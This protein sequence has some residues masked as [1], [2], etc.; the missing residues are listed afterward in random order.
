MISGIKKICN[1][2]DRKSQKTNAGYG[3]NLNSLGPSVFHPSHEIVHAKTIM[4]K[5]IEP[6]LSVIQTANRS[7]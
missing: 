4:K 2:L 6:T 3:S 1:T 7:K 5:P